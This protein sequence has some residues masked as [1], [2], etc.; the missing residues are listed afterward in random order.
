MIIK[1]NGDY[2]KKA[3]IINAL[4]EYNKHLLDNYSE[5][6][7]IK[8]QYHFDEYYASDKQLNKIYVKY[9]NKKHY[10]TKIHIDVLYN[11]LQVST[12]V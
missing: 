5:D 9:D 12:E 3:T 2:T 10:V 11:A 1:F 4:E 6:I 8:N 7:A